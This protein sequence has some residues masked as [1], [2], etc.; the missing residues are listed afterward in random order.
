MTSVRGTS[1]F[2]DEI[3][4]EFLRFLLNFSFTISALT[5]RRTLVRLTGV[6]GEIL[7]RNLLFKGR[8]V[9]TELQCKH[10]IG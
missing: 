5:P 8:G 6:S 9:L 7:S 10:S 2:K 3:L 1:S 4:K